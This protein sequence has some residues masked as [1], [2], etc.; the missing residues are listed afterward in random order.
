MR[1]CVYEIATSTAPATV[2]TYQQHQDIWQ[3]CTCCNSSL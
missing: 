3:D 2:H 1:V